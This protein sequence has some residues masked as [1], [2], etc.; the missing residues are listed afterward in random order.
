VHSAKVRIVE[1]ET[2]V[3][4]L[5]ANRFGTLLKFAFPVYIDHYVLHHI[6][7]TTDMD[8]ADY[9]YKHTVYSVKSDSGEWEFL[10]QLNRIDSPSCWSYTFDTHNEAVRWILATARC[11]PAVWEVAR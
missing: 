4:T 3:L 11:V 5:A 7:V 2:D 6:C 9:A 10:M 8:S 1:L